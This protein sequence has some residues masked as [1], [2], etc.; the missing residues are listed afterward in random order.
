MKILHI[1]YST[2]PSAKGG[3]IRSRDIIQSQRQV[4]LEV[5]AASSPFQPP[6]VPG[7]R[8]EYINEIPY[9]RSFDPLHGLLISELDQGLKIKARKTLQIL[10]FEKFLSAVAEQAQPDIIHAHS[11]FFCGI[12]A[13]RVAR[14]LRVP[15]VYEVRSLWEERSIMQSRSL[16]RHGIARMVRS[17]ETQCMRIADHVTVISGGLEKEVLNRGLPAE[18]ITLIGNAVD[19]EQIPEQGPSILS[20]PREKW[21]F[22]YVGNLSRIEG[23][24][25]LI[26]AVGNLRSEGWTNTVHF[27]GDGPAI[28]ELTARAKGIAGITFHGRFRPEQ[29]QRIYESIDIVVN[30]RRSSK[31][32]EK[33]TPLKPI[34]AMG[35]KKPVICS[36][37]AGMVELVSDRE[38]GIVFRTDDVRALEKTLKEVTSGHHDLSG[39][40]NAAYGFV[41]RERSWRANGLKYKAL[42]EN[43]IRH[44]R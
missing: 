25:L 5:L 8:I 1:F 26:D 10:S 32:T 23:L 38:T 7:K 15:C 9:Y 16:S 19:L 36:S 27:F 43:L 39:I 31:L 12:A 44:S 20:K 34:E 30:P 29:A 3:D 18:K 35:W 37:V 22:G 41:A 11:T 42:Y 28:D 2:I 14:K 13:W 17:I 21:A 6:S 24:D 40:V 4:G 33:V